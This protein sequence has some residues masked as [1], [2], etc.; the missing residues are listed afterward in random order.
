MRKRPNRAATKGTRRVPSGADAPTTSA[1]PRR[2]KSAT[3]SPKPSDRQQLAAALDAHLTER[4]RIGRALHDEIGPTLSAI[5]FQLDALRFDV[6]AL[7]PRTTELQRFLEDAMQRVRALSQEL[8]SSPVERA[9]LQ[10]ALEQLLETLRPRFDGHL[11]LDWRTSERLPGH[12]AL[13]FF[14][15]AELAL[16]N[17]ATHARASRVKV[18]VSGVG[19][20][21]IEIRD[22]GCGFEASKP[23][24]RGLG[25]LRM[26]EAARRTGATFVVASVAGRS[27][28]VK[29]RYAPSSS[30]RR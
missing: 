10:L 19:S 22:N 30:T 17:A 2:V 24:R 18:V 1:P 12:V 8:S 7:A 9:G 5:G 29:S 21:T 13:A 4:R 26:A 3:N 27:T 15:I 14:D 16:D 28:I 20:V 23:P 25:L 11:T 6:P